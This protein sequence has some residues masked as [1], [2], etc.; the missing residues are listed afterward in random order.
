M[1]TDDT[2]VKRAGRTIEQIFADFGEAYF[3]Q[4]ESQALAEA[5]EAE[6]AVISAGGG[7]VL[8]GHNRELMKGSGF[9]VCLEAA[10]R[11][12]RQRL[13]EETS[14]SGPLRPLLAIEQLK[15][16]RQPY[17]AIADWTVHTDNLTPDEVAHEVIRGWYYRHRIEEQDGISSGSDDLACEVVTATEQYP[18]LVGWGLLG[19]LGERLR[20]RGLHRAAHIISDETVFSIY[21]ARATKSLEQAGIIARSHVVR[22]GELSKSLETAAGIFDWL[23]QCRA[24]RGDTIIALGGGVVGDLAGFVAATFLRG[25]PLVHVPTSL[26]AMV[27]ASVGGKTAVNHPRAKN[28]IGVFHQPRLVVADAQTLSTLPQRELASGWAEVVKH[29][30]ILNADFLVF[31]EA[32]VSKLLKLEPETTVTAIK[33]SAAI[34]AM[35]VSE[36]EK[37]TGRR[38][39]LNYGHTTLLS[40]RLGLLSWDVVQRQ[41]AILRSFG[42]PT[43]S[44][45]VDPAEVLRAMELDKKVREKTIRWVLLTDA[46]RAVIVNDVAPQQIAAVLDSLLGFSRS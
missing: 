43:G 38:T 32:S 18:V 23:V 14:R 16:Y 20:Q 21:G 13:L 3:R 4:L 28:L 33:R 15:E 44:S 12:I 40:N 34:K 7:A 17:Y 29:G 8:D 36:D 31:L 10:P 39:L 6:R 9:V 41:S 26:V 46:G 30:L 5:C 27:D 24:E 37:E 45:D 35:I 2:I 22:P 42:L 1:D 25:M 11:T 19:S